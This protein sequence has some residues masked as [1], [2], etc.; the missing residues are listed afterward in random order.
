MD[1]VRLLRRL[2]DADFR[3][4]SDGGAL[5]VAP[6]DRLTPSIRRRIRAAKDD[7]LED[8]HRDRRLE[9]VHCVDCDVLLPLSG[10][11]CPTCRDTAGQPTCAS[12]GAHVTGP[13]LSI[14]NLCVLE[15]A[16]PMR[17]AR[18]REHEQA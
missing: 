8:M 17:S 12:C 10:V 11:R 14:C 5:M 4:K 7:L 15:A 2:R 9:T 3:I 6:A 16:T 1:S 13:D 18:R